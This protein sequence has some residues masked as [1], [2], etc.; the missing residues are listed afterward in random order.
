MKPIT[1][2]QGPGAGALEDAIEQRPEEIELILA[3]GSPCPQ[4]AGSM[5]WID[6]ARLPTG[7]ILV[8]ALVKNTDSVLR[9]DSRAGARGRGGF[10]GCSRVPQRAVT[11]CRG[12]IVGHHRRRKQSRDSPGEG[13]RPQQTDWVLVGTETGRKVIAKVAE[14]Q[15]RARLCSPNLERPRSNCSPPIASQPEV[16]SY[17]QFFVNRQSSPSSSRS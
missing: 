16:N 12:A 7:T 6:K 4:K 13:W 2:R 14:D 9:R 5:R 10:E 1:S 15:R 17:G 8:N 11:K 3:E